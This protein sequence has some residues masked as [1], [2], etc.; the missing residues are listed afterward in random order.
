M[1]TVPKRR[2]RRP[3]GE[4]TRG[5]LLA[6][7]RE[8]FAERSYDDVTVREIG[9]RAQVDPAMVN[10]WFGGKAELFAVAVLRL[11]FDPEDLTARVLDGEPARLPERAV[12]TFVTIWDAG[13]GTVA[14]PL[15]RNLTTQPEAASVM[16][17]L[18]VRRVFTP[19]LAT[20]APDEVEPRASL[21]ANLCASQLLGIGMTRY[22]LRFEPL[23]SADVETIVAA[24]APTIRRYLTGDIGG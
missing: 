20:M 16:R 15:L 4:E 6:A 24:V 2:G 13:G 18:L 19:V 1:V 3:A 22:V 5:A 12:R 14:L 8:L 17:E 21:R 9:T 7:A 11:P 10:H 23:A